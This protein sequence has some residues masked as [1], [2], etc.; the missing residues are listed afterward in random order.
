MRKSTRA[1]VARSAALL[2]GKRIHSKRHKLGPIHSLPKTALRKLRRLCLSDT[3]YREIADWLRDSYGL[4]V[5]AQIVHNAWKRM[6]DKERAAEFVGNAV[7]AN[8]FQVI[9]KAPGARRV[10]IQVMPVTADLPR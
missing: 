2:P 3:P 4:K 7:F 9:V 6:R 5:S 8:G 1:G 10:G